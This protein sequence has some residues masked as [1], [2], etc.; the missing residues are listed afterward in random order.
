MD[1]LTKLQNTK[2]SKSTK[3]TLRTKIQ[4]RGVFYFALR[5]SLHINQDNED[6]YLYQSAACILLMEWFLFMLNFQTK[7]NKK[8]EGAKNMLW[9]G[10]YPY[11]GGLRPLMSL[12]II[13]YTWV[14]PHFC[15]HMGIPIIFMIVWCPAP[16]QLNFSPLFH[17][18]PK[19]PKNCVCVLRH[20]CIYRK[21][22]I[23]L[24][25]MY[26]FIF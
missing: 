6:I 5:T 15:L 21:G 12:P 17:I 24:S 2:S 18:S 25:V 22:R 19:I 11:A 13:D 3:S 10:G 1:C 26:F 4:K 20:F 23:V 16:F 7:N 14:Y 8:S 9:G